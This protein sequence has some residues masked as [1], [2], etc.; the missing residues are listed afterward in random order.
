M[1]SSPEPGT[2]TGATFVEKEG[3]VVEG[4]AGDAAALG[5]TRSGHWTANPPL[6]FRRG[7]RPP[8]DL[9]R[10]PLLLPRC[11]APTASRH[12]LRLPHVT[13]SWRRRLPGRRPETG[14]PGRVG[15]DSSGEAA[16]RHVPRSGLATPEPAFPA[17]ERQLWGPRT[18]ALPSPCPRGKARCA[19]LAAAA[20]RPSLSPT[21]QGSYCGVAPRQPPGHAEDRPSCFPQVAPDICR[22][23]PHLEGG[24]GSSSW[25]VGG[26]NER[27]G[28]FRSIP[29]VISIG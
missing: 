10:V 23:W 21:V 25:V 18:E 11:S 3:E 29:S 28:T 24:P 8:P 16:G 2:A 26:A 9:P 6:H 22:S 19:S 4:R 1:G 14:R 20:R 27:P 12:W 7:E 15:A 5:A 17:R 13:L